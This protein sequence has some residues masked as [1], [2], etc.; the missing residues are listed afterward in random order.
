[1]ANDYYN[2][3]EF[4][5]AIKNYEKIANNTSSDFGAE[6]KYKLAFLAFLEDD[7]DY[8]EHL[9]LELSDK[10]Y[11]DFYIAKGFILL[12]D[13]Y[14]KKG[15][16]FQARATLQSIIDNYEGDDLLELCNKKILEID[17][18]NKKQQKEESNEN[19]IIDLL[20]EVDLYELFEEENISKNEK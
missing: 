7:W 1:M 6:A 14:R 4:H 17:F 5:L 18:Q 10:Y 3:S 15:N 8:S 12:S 16:L 9:I 20:N 19:L 11:N 13:I 2:L